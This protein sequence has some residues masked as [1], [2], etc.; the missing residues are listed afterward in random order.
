MKDKTASKNITEYIIAF[1]GILIPIVL[2]YLGHIYKEAETK[3]G[4]HEK[5]VE[6]AIEIMKNPSDPQT[7]ELRKWALKVL[8]KYSEV[9]IHDKAQEHILNAGLPET[10]T[11]DNPM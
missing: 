11:P 6:M 2:V 7:L 9:P 4:I 3:Q 5:Y 10:R 8:N 1:A